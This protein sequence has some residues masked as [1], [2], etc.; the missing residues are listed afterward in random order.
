MDETL[1]RRSGI[2]GEVCSKICAVKGGSNGILVFIAFLALVVGKGFSKP[3]RGTGKGCFCVDI[4]GALLLTGCEFGNVV[5]CGATITK[6]IKARVG[7]IDQGSVK[8]VQFQKTS[9]IGLSEVRKIEAY[10]A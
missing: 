8:L 3:V 2:G 9:C 10:E 6:C 5:C 4:E 7:R 1:C